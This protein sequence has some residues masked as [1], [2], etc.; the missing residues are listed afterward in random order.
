M[1]A[2]LEFC[3]CQCRVLAAALWPNTERGSGPRAFVLRRVAVL[4]FAV[5]RKEPRST[6]T[7]LF[8]M[9]GFGGT[10]GSMGGSSFQESYA[11]FTT[12]GVLARPAGL[13]CGALAAPVNPM[14]L[15]VT[16]SSSPKMSSFLKPQT[17]G[18]HVA[19]PGWVAKEPIVHMVHE[20][21]AA[22]VDSVVDNT[23]RFRPCPPR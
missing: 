2:N 20:Y 9:S 16:W 4:F 22:G 1:R 7:P 15:S 8:V 12:S 3:N 11:P 19:P 6:S 14:A 10:F 18:A 17:V 5:S 23:M 21:Q 13:P